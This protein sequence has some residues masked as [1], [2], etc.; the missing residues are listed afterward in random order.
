MGAIIPAEEKQN[1][2]ELL[3]KGKEE[4]DFPSLFERDYF[5]LDSRIAGTMYNKDIRKSVKE[6]AVGTRILLFREPDNEYDELAIVIKT[7]RM[8]KLGY[9]PRKDNPVLAR[10]MDAGKEIY[11]KVKEIRDE[12]EF[13]YVNIYIEI[14]LHED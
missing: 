7:P 8:H 12:K 2:V 1:M 13:N 10:L 5:L 9:V 11:A 3:Q 6:L 4:D 14:Y